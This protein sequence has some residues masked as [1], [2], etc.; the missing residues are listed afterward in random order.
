MHNGR[1]SV[2]KLT[3]EGKL[4]LLLS[5]F[6]AHNVSLDKEDQLITAHGEEHHTMIRLED[7]GAVDTL[8]TKNDYRY[9][10]GGNCTY[11]LNDDIFFSA[12]GF[13]W[14]LNALGE[15]EQFS[16]H[17]LEWNQ[18][19]LA[20]NGGS[21]YAP[22]IGNG[23]GE[24]WKFDSTG[25]ARLVATDLITKFEDREY[26]RHDD[27]LLGMAVD[28]EDNVYIT[29][30][31]GQRVVKIDKRG[32]KSEFYRASGKWFPT[33]LAFK[34]TSAFIL[35]YEEGGAQGGP[36]IIQRGAE[37]EVKVIF[38]YQSYHKKD[39]PKKGTL[40]PLDS[41]SPNRFMLLLLITGLVVVALVV[42]RGL[43]TQ[44]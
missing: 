1:G 26:N 11:A 18:S 19:I 31:A 3:P 36:R 12:E 24:L 40:E 39:D 4:I 16:D 33:G 21:I 13:I 42:A 20:T 27:V 32:E 15:R 5:D 34:G 28:L 35:E 44:S 8:I 14:R 2:W 41:T 25:N 7:S 10:F 23:K 37:G 6:H 22:D 9:F 43:K 38:D 17:R 30:K 29:D